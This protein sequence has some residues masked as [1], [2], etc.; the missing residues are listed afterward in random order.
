MRKEKR[1]HIKAEP[2][3]RSVDTVSGNVQ[4]AYT[5]AGLYALE[6]PQERPGEELA[7]VNDCDPLWLQQL[8]A[9][10]Q[11]YFQGERV[12]FSC[13]LDD[14]GY[15]PFHRKVLAACAQ[16][17]FGERQT[18]RWLAAEA[19]SAG[20]VRAAGQ[21]MAG[22]R[23]PLVIPCHRVLRSDGKLGGFSGGLHWKERLLALERG[24]KEAGEG[25][26]GK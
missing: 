11:R 10:L 2:I 21:A 7:R 3:R 5:A 16:I 24:V 17:D 13:P 8:A 22:N 9:D 25:I 12:R 20:A 4:L 19:G 18:Y 15:G 6:L 1:Q 23:T 14:S 26:C